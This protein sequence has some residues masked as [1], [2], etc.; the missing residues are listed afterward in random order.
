MAFAIVAAFWTLSDGALNNHECLVSVTAREMLETG[1]WVL[2]RFNGEVRL[3]K[4]PL[5]YWL[6]AS[7]AKAKLSQKTSIYE[8]RCLF[9]CVRIAE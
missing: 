8:I 2:P 3:Q 6:V 5:C 4:T 7:V 1:D 9:D